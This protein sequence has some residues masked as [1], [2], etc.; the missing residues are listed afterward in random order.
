MD[1]WRGIFLYTRTH[2]YVLR[3]T[4]GMTQYFT[5]PE[6]IRAVEQINH[7]LVRPADM[8]TLTEQYN[9]DPWLMLGLMRQE[10]AYRETVRSWVGA[11]GYIQVMPATGAKVAFYWVMQATLRKIWK[12]LKRTCAMESITSRSYG[13]F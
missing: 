4:T 13:T 12:T 10:S 11:I 8:W 2:H 1:A 9:V 6:D 7:P 3:Y 5:E